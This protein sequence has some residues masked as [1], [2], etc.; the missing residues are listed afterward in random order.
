MILARKSA[1]KRESKAEALLSLFVVLIPFF[2]AHILR[3][4]I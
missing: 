4:A 2:I 3:P 1:I